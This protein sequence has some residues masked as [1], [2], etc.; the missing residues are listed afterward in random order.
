M[1][2]IGQDFDSSTAWHICPSPHSSEWYLT[3][4]ICTSVTSNNN[5]NRLSTLFT[6]TRLSITLY[7]TT[8]MM[9]RF[10]VMQTDG[11]SNT[12]PAGHGPL[13]VHDCTPPYQLH[14]NNSRYANSTKCG[15]EQC[16]VRADEP[17]WL[18]SKATVTRH[19]ASTS[20]RRH[21]AF[22]LCCH[23]NKTRAPIADPPNSAQLE[24]T[25]YHFPKLHLGL[26]SSVGMQW[27]TDTHTDVCDQYTFHIIYDSREM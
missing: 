22:G 7:S 12:P 15:Y 8:M 25:P 11:G 1:A 17:R 26:Y 27:G 9:S 21:F 4:I 2:E 19:R 5:Y 20:T 3:L 16:E 13:P 23:S 10:D 6:N 24:G 14:P 18:K